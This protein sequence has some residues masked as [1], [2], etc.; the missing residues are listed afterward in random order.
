MEAA[1][2]VYDAVANW[3]RMFYDGIG[4]GPGKWQRAHRHDWKITQ[5]WMRLKHDDL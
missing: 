5:L 4:G 2:T 3:R 1:E